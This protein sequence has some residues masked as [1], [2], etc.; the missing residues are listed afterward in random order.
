MRNCAKRKEEDTKTRY[1]LDR[2]FLP[3]SIHVLRYM[4]IIY[5]ICILSS[6]KIQGK[7]RWCGVSRLHWQSYFEH[8]SPREYN[9]NGVHVSLSSKLLPPKCFLIIVFFFFS[10]FVFFPNFQVCLTID[11]AGRLYT[12]INNNNKKKVYN[13][14]C[15][16]R[17]QKHEPWGLIKTDV[18]CNCQF[19]FFCFF[20]VPRFAYTTC[21][22]KKC[23][24]TLSK[25]NL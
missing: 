25:E 22:L 2:S 24:D 15:R 16:R 18:S 3:C 19:L 8:E 11:H 5:S 12:T 1:N 21:A 7:S 13:K 14:F 23:E 4:S 9:V 10:L 6:Y 17:T 20:L